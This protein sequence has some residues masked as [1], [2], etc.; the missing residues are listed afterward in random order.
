M[1]FSHTNHTLGTLDFTSLE[2]LAPFN[3]FLEHHW[4][5]QKHDELTTFFLHIPVTFPF[6]KNSFSFS[7]PYANY[8]VG[9]I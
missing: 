9:K 7:R 3:F 5:L 1:Y 8:V 6:T 4:G 2:H